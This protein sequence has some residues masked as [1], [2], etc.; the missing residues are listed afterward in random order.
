MPT[1]QQPV[2]PVNTEDLVRR[3]RQGDAEAFC[4]LART[5]DHRLYQQAVALCRD[6]A[7]AGDLASETLVEAWK[8]IARFNGSCRF[9]TW[10]YAILV[11]RYQKFIRRAQSRPLSLSRLPR[12]EAGDHATALEAVTDTAPTPAEGLLQQEITEQLQTAMQELPEIH[13][14][15]LLLRFYQGASIA[16]MAAALDLPVGTVKSR[17]HHALAQMRQSKVV[18]NLLNPE[19]DT[20]V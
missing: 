1:I 6:S 11:H 7:A 20:K 8:C 5:C 9:S 2:D 4:V 15:V 3:S 18:L 16:E 12:R 19:G 13:Q 17:L 10:L 14:Q